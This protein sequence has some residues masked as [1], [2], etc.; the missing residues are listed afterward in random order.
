MFWE[1]SGEVWLIGVFNNENIIYL[2][3]YIKDIVNFKK[4]NGKY[5]LVVCMLLRIVYIEKE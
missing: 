4:E 1:V 5:Y 2:Y 3:I